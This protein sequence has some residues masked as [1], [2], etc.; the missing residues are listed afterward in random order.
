MYGR[1][2]TGVFL[3]HTFC[4]AE[5]V[6]RWCGD[7]CI[8]RQEQNYGILISMPHLSHPHT[9]W[10]VVILSAVLAAS[11]SASFFVSAELVVIAAAVGAIF[12]L[13]V[14][15]PHW[16]VYALAVTAPMSGLT[17]DFSRSES[18]SRVPYL[19]AV[20]APVVDMLAVIFLCALI[21]VAL[22]R[23]RLLTWRALASATPW[24]GL[25]V[26]AAGI[27][28]AAA[29][30]NFF[31]TAVKGWVRPYLFAVLAFA[32]PVMVVARGEL[33]LTRAL[34]W[35]EI[36][37]M[38]GA[39]LGLVGFVTA[40]PVGF[41]RVTPSSLFGWWPFG[42]NHNVLAE[43]LT[44][45]MPFAWWYAATQHGQGSI[46]RKKVAVAMATLITLAALL[47]FSRAAWIVAAAQGAFFVWWK[48]RAHIKTIAPKIT[49]VGVALAL[50]LFFIQQT[51]VAE[52]SNATRRDLTGIAL[53]YWARAPWLGHGP[54][55]FVPI[56]ADTAAFRMDYGEALDAHGVLQKLL[57]ETG[58]IGTLAFFVFL[59]WLMARLWKRRHDSWYAMVL[60]T[61]LSVWLYQLFNTGYFAGKVWVL[62]G[63]A[64]AAIAL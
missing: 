22:T 47:T 18:L 33:L 45:I 48:Y 57:L 29:D 24:L 5:R 62:I 16:G 13:F 63:V 40:I 30:A 50:F 4:F 58:L 54:G 32:A 55:T 51:T 64:L 27:S 3:Q 26:C 10:L 2:I 34:L 43:S 15:R 11:V 17:V 6:A 53:T 28:A 61:V 31:G 59:A 35:Y 38:L 60:L 9:W 37:A 23:P 19:G 14:S 52:T 12:F 49:A 46:D 44:A 36:T 25:L 1:G 21:A 20:D 39:L 41:A 7:A 42:T 56:V 8:C